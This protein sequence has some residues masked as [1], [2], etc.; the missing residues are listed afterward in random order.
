[1]KDAR[2]LCWESSVQRTRAVQVVLGEGEPGILRSIL[3]AQGF[4]VVAH[5]RGDD[6]LRRIVPLTH[7]TVMVFDAGISALAVIDAQI[8]SD[9]VPIVVVWP[10]DTYTSAAEERVDPSSALLELGNAVRRVVE[11]HEPI[12]IPEAEDDEPTERVAAVSPPAFPDR[13]AAGGGRHAL[14]LISAWAIALTALA[15]IGLAVPIA[16]R[17]PEPTG[18]L[19]PLRDRPERALT[20]DLEGP[21]RRPAGAEREPSCVGPAQVRMGPHPVHG[22]AGGRG[23]GCALGHAKHG[24]P[25]TRG[26]GHGRPDDPGKG[27]GRGEERGGPS[28]GKTSKND[29]AGQG[30]AHRDHPRQD[31]RDD[32]PAEHGGGDP[33]RGS[34]GGTSDGDGGGSDGPGKSEG[35]D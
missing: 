15:A 16:F 4:D 26:Q 19:H 30:G 12:R 5:A 17:A 35:K 3:E 9:Y 20:A 6:E 28:K 1:L 27:S 14:V 25:G 2:T 18:T 10:K 34:R 11:R 33:G 13:R 23:R 32:H 24:P 7:P 31:E 22:A 8:R 29:E 21:G